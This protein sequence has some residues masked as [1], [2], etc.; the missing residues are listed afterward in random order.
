MGRIKSASAAL[1][2]VESGALVVEGDG[3]VPVA[4]ESRKSKLRRLQIP[5]E[6]T[7]L[8]DGVRLAHGDE[9]AS[10]LI[11]DLHLAL[12]AALPCPEITGRDAHSGERSRKLNDLRGEIG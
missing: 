8:L 1:T 11:R 2:E 10:P 5:G 12:A 9:N 6:D 7:H 4:Q 3:N